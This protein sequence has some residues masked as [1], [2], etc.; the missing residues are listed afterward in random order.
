[1]SELTNQIISEE[2]IDL[3]REDSQHFEQSLEQNQGSP[4]MVIYETTGIG[5]IGVIIGRHWSVGFG[6]RTPTERETLLFH[7]RMTP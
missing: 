3:L 2:Q 1:M 6:D 4:Q 5:V 7:S